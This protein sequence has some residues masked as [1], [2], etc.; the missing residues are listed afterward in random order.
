MTGCFFYRS[1]ELYKSI[2]SR[3]NS[4]ICRFIGFLEGVYCRELLVIKRR[5]FRGN[6][7]GLSPMERIFQFAISVD[8]FSRMPDRRILILGQLGWQKDFRECFFFNKVL[9]L[10]L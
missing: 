8:V 9:A 6:W 5:K 2:I 10:N 4:V 1:I 3:L 7:E